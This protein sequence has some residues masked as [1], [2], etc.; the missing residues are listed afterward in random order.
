M[1]LR[2]GN[3]FFFVA[4]KSIFGIKNNIFPYTLWYPKEYNLVDSCGESTEIM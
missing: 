3:I 4:I 1:N 2:E